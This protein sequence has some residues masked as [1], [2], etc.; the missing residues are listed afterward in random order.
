M[1]QLAIC[2]TGQRSRPCVD[3]IDI[4]YE[5][6]HWP[7]FNLADSAICIGAFLLLIDLVRNQPLCRLGLGPTRLWDDCYRIIASC[8]AKAQPTQKPQLIKREDVYFLG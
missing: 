8:W 6:H 4:Y 2:M 7:V 5:N 1:E 3:F